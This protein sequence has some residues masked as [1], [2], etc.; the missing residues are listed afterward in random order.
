MPRNAKKA[1]IKAVK[2]AVVKAIR[3][4]KAKRSRNRRTRPRR[5]RRVAKSSIPSALPG[6]YSGMGSTSGWNQQSMTMSGRDL[7]YTVT[8]PALT[9]TQVIT[10][11][12]F[13]PQRLVQGSRLAQFGALWDKFRFTKLKFIYEPSVGTLQAGALCMS[14]D[15]DV[16][17]DYSSMKGQMLLQKLS[18]TAHNLTTP[19]YTPACLDIKDKRFFSGLLYTE[20]EANSDPRN[21]YAGRLWVTSAGGLAAGTYGRIY[22]DWTIHFECPN[23]D[24]E[25]EDGTAMILAPSGTYIS[26]TYPWGD[27]TAII[28]AF[29]TVGAYSGADFVTFRSDAVLGSVIQFEA[30]GF[31]LVNMWRSGAA[32]GTGAFSS[33]VY[34]NVS[35]NLPSNPTGFI[36]GVT[37]MVAGAGSTASS[38]FVL[39]YA[40]QTGATMSS[41]ADAGVTHNAGI[42][43]VSR[44]D[45]AGV[46]SGSLTLAPPVSRDYLSCQLQKLR[47]ELTQKCRVSD[48]V[49]NPILSSAATGSITSAP[50]PTGAPTRSY[51]VSATASFDQENI[52]ETVAAGL[53]DKYVLVPRNENRSRN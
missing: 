31:Y 52:I 46:Q 38:W 8:V 23:I 30:P 14:A 10:S 43:S 24:E 26:S 9:D 20:P 16:L 47:D 25:F 4:K 48:V 21:V 28:N 15:P 35:T 34:N 36:S 27:F 11:F 1:E 41:T 42:V 45:L 3:P 53:K 5:S 33:C 19:L 39:V 49:I 29:P 40:S 32:M 22:V 37:Y 13:N 6:A 18:S 2:K 7:A 17:D 51:D 44:I 12:L 50:D